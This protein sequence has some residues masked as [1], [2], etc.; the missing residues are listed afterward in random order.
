MN[1]RV[2]FDHLMGTQEQRRRDVQSERL[3]NTSVLLGLKPGDARHSREEV[4]VS[5]ISGTAVVKFCGVC[6]LVHSFRL[7]AALI[8]FNNALSFV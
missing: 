7:M 6:E 5:H 3:G 8:L 4:D 2:A 1:F